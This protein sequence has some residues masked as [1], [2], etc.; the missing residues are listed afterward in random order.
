METKIESVVLP[1]ELHKAEMLMAEIRMEAYV[2]LYNYGFRPDPENRFLFPPSLKE[3]K[4]EWFKINS[5]LTQEMI[6]N[7]DPHTLGIYIKQ[8]NDQL[9]QHIRQYVENKR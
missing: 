6:D 9:K 3:K 4:P 7:S 2:T 5:R 1:D 8:I